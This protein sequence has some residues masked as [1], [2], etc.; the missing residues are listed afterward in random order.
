[1]TE[2][3]IS[4]R[5]NREDDLVSVVVP[6]YNA[7]RFIGLALLS[8]LGQTHRNLEVLVVDDGS[9]DRTAA[10]AA[11]FAAGD[12]RVRLFNRPNS[13]V[14]AA[15]NF[16]IAQATGDLIATL[17]ADDIWHP[18]KI[19]QQVAVLRQSSDA[20]GVVYCWSLAIDGDDFVVLPN[21]SQSLATGRVLTA[22]AEGNILG[23]GSTPLIRRSC[24]QMVGGYDATLPADLRGG[25]D[26][27]FYLSLAAV[28]E[29]GAVRK[30]LVAYRLSPS[31]QSLNL[32]VM[33][34]SIAAVDDWIA[35]RWPELPA[36]IARRRTHSTNAYLA[37]QALRKRKLAQA[38]DYQA[39]AIRARPA[40]LFEMQ[41][42]RFAVRALRVLFGASPMGRGPRLIGRDNGKLHWL[43]DV[44][45]VYGPSH[46][47]NPS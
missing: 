5:S 2:A 15:R 14:A 10:I 6:A 7:E 39:R 27:R 8:V 33:E 28:C 11:T 42:L 43:A 17:D 31:G 25:E 12:R 38:L 18:E 47:P 16:A 36:G 22:L 21:W 19:A 34:K 35:R 32:P 44:P 45:I 9:T 4:D 23:N 29:F 30:H 41:F 40:A 24:V 13:G 1:M 3:H 26:W 46:T 37:F 20:V